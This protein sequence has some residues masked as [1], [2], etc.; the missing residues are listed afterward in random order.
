MFPRR[1]AHDRHDQRD[2]HRVQDELVTRRRFLRRAGL[3][4]GAV[5]VLGAGTL[6]YRAYDQGVLAAGDGPAYD[7]WDTWDDGAGLL[8]LVGAATLAPSPHNAQAWLFD[9]GRHHVDVFADHTRTTGAT[10]P[11][12]RELHV[13]LGA[14]IENMV[15]HA[16]DR[17]LAADV[18]LLP[19]GARANHAARLAVTP[20]TRRATV[21]GAQIPRRHTNR[22]PFVVDKD[23]PATALVQMRALADDALPDLDV[24]WITEE[25]A[26]RDLG[27][28]LVDATEAIVADDEQGAS[29]YAWFRQSWDEI[30]RRRD[31]ITIDAAGLPELTTTLAKLL[32][33]QSQ[34]E[35]GDA[36]IASTR[37]RH[38]ATAAAYGIVLAR[39]ASDRRQQLDGGRL[40][41]RVHLWATSA[42]LALHHMN[43]L[44]ERADRERQVGSSPR[45]GS[46]LA[47]VVPDGWQALS[48]FRI[49]HP[50]HTPKRSPRR[51]VHEVMVR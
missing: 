26:R 14:A 43:Q 28:L 10:D 38:T 22:Y 11:F 20:A 35:T 29:D 32:P 23:V 41:Q 3:G 30:Q 31:G 50:T 1:G 33:A 46:A 24:Y 27:E 5:A 51:G 12:L 48:L 21:L 49:G 18:E 16:S 17:G 6:S 13:G 40:L 8:P 2:D 36:W 34:R 7:A 39:D 37:D 44:T 25:H 45:F 4:L 19:Y 42:D 47:D 9:V 15:L